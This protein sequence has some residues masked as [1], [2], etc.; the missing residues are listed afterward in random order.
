[1]R[2]WGHKLDE[3]AEY[4]LPKAKVARLRR[5]ASRVQQDEQESV[6]GSFHETGRETLDISINGQW[7][8]L[9][10]PTDRL[11]TP[12]ASAV[13]TYCHQLADEYCPRKAT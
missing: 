7:I 6:V 2:R 11:T 4:T 12:A 3:E 13:T 8:R 10:H 5:L 1:M 9:E